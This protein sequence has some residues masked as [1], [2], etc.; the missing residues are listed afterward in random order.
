MSTRI[1][2]IKLSV[3]ATSFNDLK[4]WQTEFAGK[5]KGKGQKKELIHITRNMPKRA[6]EV[7]NDGS[8]Y[9]VIKGLITAR[10]RILE[11]RPIIHNETAHCGIVYD[12]ELI[13]VKLNPRRPFQGWR[14]LEEK[15]A[16]PDNAKGTTDW[17]EEMH[18]ELVKLGIL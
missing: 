5:K 12:P 3:G 13:R 4:D 8:I 15:D 18:R 2:L 11:L 14:Y 6:A 17:P 9:W 7:L 10:N 1:H 16:P